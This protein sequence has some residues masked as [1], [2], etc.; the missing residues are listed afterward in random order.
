MNKLL[1]PSILSAD[2][3]NLAQQ[4]ALVEKGGADWIHCDVM[5][6][7]FVPNLTFGPIVIEAVKKSTTLPVDVHL[8]I[9]NPD[10]LLEH[11][12]KSGAD[13]LV[14]HQEEV[15]HL[16]RTI[17]KI[18]ELGCK[19]GVAIN[20]S[21]PVSSVR[22]VIELVDLVLI[23]SVNPGF[24]GQKFINQT[25]RKIEEAANIKNSFDLDFLI[26]VDGGIG[27]DNIVSIS[28]AGCEVFVAGNAVFGKENITAATKELK[29]LIIN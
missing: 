4:I 25:F 1:A 9:K 27:K 8:M 24:G 10:N 19:P 11:F 21:T 20:P 29:Q 28:N 16:N 15:V 12:A 13:Y 22:E 3:A 23:M 6:G 7:Q 18:R 26:Q 14:V 2:M 17:T 5:D